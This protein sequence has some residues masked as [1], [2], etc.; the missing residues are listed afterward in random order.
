M[1]TIATELVA[2]YEKT[3]FRVLE[4][5]AFTLR[6]GMTSEE[7]KAVYVELGVSKAAFLTAWNPLSQEMSPEANDRAQALLVRKL[8]LDGF[9]TWN[10]LGLDPSGDWPGEDSVF[11]PGISLE[12]AKTLGCQFHQNAIV[13]TGEDATPQLVLLK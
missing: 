3:E 13:W 8:A 2:A 6:I 5:R 10:G 12:Q 7:L 1:S 11:V 9:V 4:P